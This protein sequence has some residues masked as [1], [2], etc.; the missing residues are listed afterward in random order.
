MAKYSVQGG[1]K[2]FHENPGKVRNVEIPER[3]KSAPDHPTAYPV[4]I[5]DAE[6]SLLRDANLHGYE[7][8][9]QIGR[10]RGPGGLPSYNGYGEQAGGVG[11]GG[12]SDAGSYGGGYAG[13]G[14]STAGSYD[15]STGGFT[16]RGSG[17]SAFAA[18]RQAALED[19][20]ARV[21]SQ[22]PMSLF[23]TVPPEDYVADWD[24][25]ATPEDIAKV[26]S[27]MD[28]YYGRAPGTTRQSFDDTM[29]GNQF[30]EAEMQVEQLNKA[31]KQKSSPFSNLTNFPYNL[32]TFVPGIR[33][34][35]VQGP[36]G[37]V[38]L[39]STDF[40]WGNVPG[41][42][43]AYGTYLAAPGVLGM[44]GAP[45]ARGFVDAAVAGQN[46]FAE[47][48]SKVGQSVGEFGR[49][50]ASVVQDPVGSLSSLY[51]QLPEGK[52]STTNDG[53][54][55]G[56]GGDGRPYLLQP[57]VSTPVVEA[58]FAAT[59]VPLTPYEHL[60]QKWAGNQFILAPIRRQ[61]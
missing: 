3:W 39:Q 22:A 42:L 4:L 58:P 50:V 53:G 35:V 57:T 44:V 12:L 59:P 21:T 46:P 24:F 51:G 23:N 15:P 60:K 18:A 20:A 13:D 41:D 30:D 5:T 2:N 11:G 26:M 47:T 28:T 52:P 19:Q 6:K 7:D 29:V 55:W 17:D 43:A 10:G 25:Q 49:D 8:P 38:S 45:M 14:S 1:Y 32:P 9:S 56:E 36:K 37:N 48:A 16:G 54:A 34:K 27:K 33:S 31:Y 40:S 61:S